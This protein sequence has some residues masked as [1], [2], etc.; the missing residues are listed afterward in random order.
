[1]RIIS[2][3]LGDLDLPETSIFDFPHG[4][5]GFVMEKTFVL[6]LH[7]EDSPFAF[8]QSTI[9]PNLTF[10]LVDPFSFFPDYRFEI[11]DDLAAELNIGDDNLPQIWN[12]V[13]VPGGNVQR[14]T[15][16]LLAPIIINA[17]DRVGM[18]LVLERTA[19]TTQHQLLAPGT[20][21]EANVGTQPQIG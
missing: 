16:N 5:P 11:N 3:R 12:I 19:Y 4:L 7:A 1:M 20:G 17:N 15:A 21:G 18:Q 10:L 14:M 2:T 8:L 6:L 9:E 13:T